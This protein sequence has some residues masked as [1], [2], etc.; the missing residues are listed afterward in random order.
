MSEENNSATKK[1][2]V[3]QEIANLPQIPKENKNTLTLE[4]K[5]KEEKK[6]IEKK[7]E[8]KLELLDILK[9]FSPGT[10]LRL[11]IDDIQRAELGALIVFEKE[12][13]SEILEGGFKVNCRFSA[14]RLVELSKM[15]GAIILS[16][17]MKRILYAN[18]LIIPNVEIM[19][20]ET[21]TRH[22]AAERAAKQFKTVVIAVSERKNKVTL[23][24]DNMSYVL[25]PTSEVL[26]KASETLQV[27]EKQTDVFND[28]LSNI[29]LLEISDNVMMSDVSSVL[30]R[31]EMIK[32]ISSMV[33]KYLVELGKEGIVVSMRLKELTKN[34][35]LEEDMILRDYFGAKAMK[36][37][38]ILESMNF[39]FL[40]ET[41]NISRMLFGEV[42]DN[43]ISPS[44][45]RILSKTNLLEKDVKL[46]TKHYKNL[47]NILKS[48]DS[49]SD[50]LGGQEPVEFFKI[51]IKNLKEKIM[52]GKKV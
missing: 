6:K 23:Y 30:Q 36:A 4:L 31:L 3:I 37:K 9:L 39:D 10:S 8:K 48:E 42:S 7:D 33:K 13:L 5:K 52:I 46:L 15:D 51:E 44:G 12:G 2:M 29:N 50:V 27:L 25:E 21:G 11:A 34:M 40:L 32:K 45:I 26:R 16:K 38:A 22:K 28:I 47:G 17:D 43:H 14:Q 49:L 35:N 20:K 24:Y 41:S 18:T 1:E 19:T